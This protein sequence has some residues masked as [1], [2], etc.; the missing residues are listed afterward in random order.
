VIGGLLNPLLA[1]G[2]LLV[3]VP[4][5]IH[6]WNRQRHKP[7]AFGA[8][9]FVLAAYRRTRRRTQ[10]ENLL[11]LLLRMAAVALLALALSR[12]FAGE[13]S[14]LAAL[15]ESRRDLVLIIDASAST[16][17]REPAG[18]VFER[19]LG[20][21]RDLLGELDGGRG[22]RARLVL[23]DERPRLLSWR[24]PEEALSVLAT[25]EAPSDGPLELA[26][27]VAEVLTSLE[28]DG[29]ALEASQV[30]LRLLT[31]LQR[32]SFEPDE[33]ES[34]GAD[35]VEPG[36]AL[37]DRT[38]PSTAGAGGSAA[39]DGEI[40]TAPN[41][42]R[43]ELVRV[44]D[45]LAALELTLWVEDLGPVDPLPENLGITDLEL[46][47]PVLGP[48]LPVDLAVDVANH[49]GA[50]A[51]GVR[52]VLVL[53]G[54]RLPARELDLAPGAVAREV[55]TV[56]FPSA[57]THT[58]EAELEVDR[59]A[60]DDRRTTV[61]DV[62]DTVQV[63]LV[64]G[65]PDA[66]AIEFD[67]VGLFAAALA[68][69]DDGALGTAEFSPFALEEC[70]VAELEDERRTLE[71]HDVVVLANV[72]SLS[73]RAAERLVQWVAA[74]GGL[75][76]SAGD[77]V[78]PATYRER[79]FRADG[80]GLLPAEPLEVVAVPSRR[81]G[82]FRVQSFDGEHPALRFFADERWR[83]L[84]TEVPIYS[85]L[86]VRPLPDARVLAALD[87]GGSPLLLERPFDAGRILL[88]TTSL[89]VAWTRLPES[90]RTLVP[91]AHELVRHAGRGPLRRTVVGLGAPLH[92]EF[93]RF[94]REPVWSGP[95]GQRRSLGG[96]PSQLP[97]GRW[98]VPAITETRRAG[99]YRVEAEGE[100][101]V[102]F[103]V[104]AD[105]REGRLERLPP[106]LLSNLHP[107]LRAAGGESRR[108]EGAEDPAR[109]ELWRGIAAAC[110]LAL[111]AESLFSAWLGW[112][113]GP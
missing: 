20:R 19:I 18:T 73:T 40:A 83:P 111:V 110:L 8:M 12:P 46:L 6:L 57:G 26:A 65:A 3:V 51:L 76:I 36:L 61:V 52:L 100:A 72:E 37:P 112:R 14:P 90:A 78:S 102:V 68:P 67:E 33:A 7:L 49:G 64:N 63:L 32:R 4:L 53:D 79:L 13:R 105:P 5:A 56:T 62:P 87:S 15:T 17:Y 25:L 107:T 23:G 11:L 9:R 85:Y 2:A 92:P 89:D 93:P 50:E 55:W 81:D 80:S 101:A 27:A 30:E 43:G 60:F 99:L 44:L 38:E 58:L 91:L 109:G 21:A 108:D 70:D 35:E 104:Q 106:Q 86:A 39:T 34:V 10:L 98:S 103:A 48:G 28:E 97:G 22:D 59:L 96:E 41:S 45:R 31:D 69:P 29:S 42:S 75:L 95:E 82:Y 1:F 94:P 24:S 74:G 54:Q 71:V 113:R 77:R 16:G 88:Y 66:S 47:S 84:L